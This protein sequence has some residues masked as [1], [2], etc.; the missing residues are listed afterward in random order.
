MTITANNDS[1]TYGTAQ[2]LQ[3]HRIHR[4][5]LGDRQRRL[6]HGR[7]RNQHGARTVPATV[8]SYPIVPSA[9]TGTGLGN[10]TITYV[11]G[12]L[13]VNP[14]TLTITANS[15]N[16]VYGQANPTLTVSYAGFVNGDTSSSLT[17]QPTVTTTATTTSPAGSYPITA[18]GAVDSELHD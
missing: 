4:S 1:K 15:Q 3:Q 9:A 14:A 7:D 12:T 17:T 13:T 16:K 2:D 18:S 5:W 10:Y 11:N 6:H 8:G